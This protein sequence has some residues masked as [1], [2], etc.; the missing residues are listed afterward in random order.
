M[1]LEALAGARRHRVVEEEKQVVVMVMELD[2]SVREVLVD[3]GRV[4]V[5]VWVLADKY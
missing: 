5:W 1:Q 2:G 4:G 3:S